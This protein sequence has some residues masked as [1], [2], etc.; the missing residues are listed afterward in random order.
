MPSGEQED[1]T[2]P[3][4]FLN[5]EFNP[6]CVE[7]HSL[8]AGETFLEGASDDCKE[9]L[10]D[11]SDLTASC[12]GINCS[13]HGNCVRQPLGG[14]LRAVCACDPGYHAEQLS[15]IADDSIGPCSQESCG[16]HGTCYFDG[17]NPG[18]RCEEGFFA[19]ELTCLS[20]T[21]TNMG[22]PLVLSEVRK[23]LS[24]LTLP[25]SVEGEILIDRVGP[26]HWTTIPHWFF[27]SPPGARIE[28]W[29]DIGSYFS[30]YL[31]EP[32]VINMYIFT[33]RI[34]E[35][36]FPPFSARI[37][38]EVKLDSDYRNIE[39][40]VSSV[41]TA[42]Y[43]KWHAD[44][45]LMEVV[46]RCHTWKDTEECNKIPY[47]VDHR[48][49]NDPPGPDSWNGLSKI[50]VGVVSGEWCLECS[51]EE[52]YNEYLPNWG[53]FHCLATDNKDLNCYLCHKSW[54][55]LFLPITSKFCKPRTKR[56]MGW[57]KVEKNMPKVL[58]EM[59]GNELDELARE[60]MFNP[61]V[62]TAMG[63]LGLFAGKVPVTVHTHR[64]PDEEERVVLGLKPDSDG[65]RLADSIDNCPNNDNIAQADCDGD[66]VGDA[67][68]D[69]NCIFDMGYDSVW[70]SAWP[71]EQGVD[72]RQMNPE[73]VLGFE[74]TGARKDQVATHM[75]SLAYCACNNMDEEACIDQHCP[76]DGED[77]RDYEG[78]RGWYP[79]SW[80]A[81]GD[82]VD[83]PLDEDGYCAPLPDVPYMRTDDESD[84]E[85]LERVTTT[86]FWRDEELPPDGERVSENTTRYFKLRAQPVEDAARNPAPPSSAFSYEPVFPLEYHVGPIG[87]SGLSQGIQH[88]Y[89]WRVYLP[90]PRKELGSLWGWF[91]RCAG[92]WP[93]CDPEL[94]VISVDL[95]TGRMVD[96]E[97]PVY[98]PGELG[99]LDLE[100]YAVAAA[101]A[102][103]GR[104]LFAFGGVDA[105]GAYSDELWRG[106]RHS[107]L[108]WQRLATGPQTPAATTVPVGEF[109]LE[110]NVQPFALSRAE[111]LAYVA[112]RDSDDVGV[113][114]LDRNQLLYTIPG[115]DTPMG[116]SLWDLRGELWVANAGGNS[117]AVVDLGSWEIVDEIDLGGLSPSL[118]V[119]EPDSGRLFVRADQQV[120]PMR[121]YAVLS[122]DVAEREVEQAVA[123]DYHDF[124]TRDAMALSPDGQRL[125]VGRD[126][127]R[128]VDV[129]RTEDLT[130]IAS[131]QL[132]RSATGLALAFDGSV[133]VVTSSE[134]G[135]VSLYDTET[136]EELASIAGIP[137]AAG[138]ALD[139][140]NSFA[141]VTSLGLPGD[142]GDD[143]LYVIDLD[144]AEVAYSVPVGD[145]PTAVDLWSM[146][147]QAFVVNARS[148]TVT[149]VD[150]LRL[151]YGTPEPRAGAVLLS[152]R[153]GEN[154][155]LY[156]GQ[157]AAGTAAD[158]WV[159]NL[160]AGSWRR[161]SDGGEPGQPALAYPSMAAD[162][163]AGEL[164]LFGGLGPDG[165]ESASL[166]RTGPGLAGIEELQPQARSAAPAPRRGA[167]LAYLPQRKAL[168]AFGGDSG[169]QALGDSWLY[170][171]DQ[172][173]WVEITP[174]CDSQPCPPARS[175]AA[176]VV[177]S[178]GQRVAVFGGQDGKQPVGVD[179]WIQDLDSG[180]WR[181]E[182]TPTAQP[183]VHEAGLLRVAY[184][185]KRLGRRLDAELD[186][187]PLGDTFGW[188]RNRS[189]R[190]LGQL[191]I[192]QPGAYKL[193][194]D[195]RGGFRVFID[196]ELVGMGHR[197]ADSLGSCRRRSTTSEPVALEAGWHDLVV[198]L[199]VCRRGGHIEVG[200]AGGPAGAGVIPAERFRSRSRGGLLRKGY[201]PFLWWLLETGVDFDT[202][203]A[204][205]DWGKAVPRVLGL[206]WPN[207]FA[208]GWEG[209]LTIE[210][211]GAYRFVADSDDGAQLEVAG[212]R[213]IDRLWSRAGR[214]VSSP[215]WL[216]PGH[217]D[218]RFLVRER[219]GRAH[220]R[221]RFHESCPELGGQ[222]LPARRCSASLLSPQGGKTGGLPGSLR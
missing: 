87:L 5:A 210:T 14:E 68:D 131:V 71:D 122:I 40:R 13:G 196:G 10:A 63:G 53:R 124:K 8:R 214:W 146:N 143:A 81:T 88:L 189:Y 60:M 100:G 132:D 49:D 149:V 200:F 24:E 150:H 203:P 176:A 164:Y 51:E 90:D 130:P 94:V 201:F 169:A 66:G 37:M 154:L 101:P 179:L 72:Q 22:L 117:L 30:V 50:N 157:T 174:D 43:G 198:D 80:S 141:A 194:V 165:Q 112:H 75:A 128:Q 31:S 69:T 114:D 62:L 190:W 145:R 82:L 84:V 123:Y 213:I 172:R 23:V 218:I 97:T 221:L 134:Q 175:G 19:Q 155:M 177:L 56:N 153:E 115:F 61:G 111:R 215:V 92:G 29:V 204:D 59:L 32:I 48:C 220:A 3:F 78:F 159:L 182:E 171:L 44:S 121:Q 147:E 83:C 55:C 76:E 108:V 222:P 184:R 127:Y 17:V 170:S 74:T 219:R 15:C 70:S 45:D 54:T 104:D 26:I 126:N 34:R 208:V 133:L 25:N 103:A 105:A 1:A 41:E 199:S 16:G 33:R 211:A 160:E 187:T 106:S 86:W 140:F 158:T 152:D 180:N 183:G 216:E 167:A 129:Y 206:R 135:L 116:L 64:E 95:E 107:P 181:R 4:Y 39:M 85:P 89:P 9:L 163:E 58:N 162:P 138:I 65:D 119:A 7:G 125:Y 188:G 191:R 47:S 77:H 118:L 151:D 46:E 36:Y 98:A 148:D 93:L 110:I 42:P 185:G 102:P 73:V 192:D 28:F 27:P 67:C 120:G 202:T 136:W 137:Y 178:D 96:F 91:R 161:V 57:S 193:A 6:K 79:I 139:D 209:K 156:G 109:P 166:W 2:D 205:D 20:C 173:R 217:H 142:T 38:L 207:H 212:Q 113:I 21:G 35:I 99:R 168:Y 52:F 144:R 12:D 186:P 195:A 197:P 11:C 18:C